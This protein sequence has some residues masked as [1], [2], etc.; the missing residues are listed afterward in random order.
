M[1][2]RPE[3]QKQAR[4]LAPA[5]P[6]QLS[7]RSTVIILSVLC[8][9]GIALRLSH[10][11]DVTSRTPDE[12][13][14]AN[15]AQRLVADGPPGLP[16]LID[17]YNW[18]ATRWIYPPPM[19]AGYLVLLA[20][21]MKI[22]TPDMLTGAWLSCFFSVLSLA[23]LAV[24]G[25]RFL[26]P[27]AAIYAVFGLSVSLCDLV[28]ARRC[29]QDAL[30]GTLG[31]TMVWAACEIARDHTRWWSYA[32]LIATGSFSVCVKE[33]G[34]VIYGGCVL[35]VLL[36]LF[37]RKA[38]RAMAG[39]IVAGLAAAGLSFY[40]LILAAGGLTPLLT[41]WQ[42]MGGALKDN[43]YAWEYQNLPWYLFFRGFWIVGPVNLLLAAFA[44]VLS[45]YRPAAHPLL[46]LFSWITVLLVVVILAA[47]TLENFRYLSPVYGPLYILGGIGLSSLLEI[48]ARKMDPGAYK[49]VAAVAVVIV[50]IGAMSQYRHFEQVYVKKSTPDLSLKL[51]LDTEG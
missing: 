30:V 50:L 20:A 44:V 32:V 29:W 7:R 12:T 42:H 27:T 45:V 40:S 33:I 14:Y 11:D 8:L 4:K 10:M 36:I 24:I 49:A 21:G 37:Q 2:P 43:P 17:Q 5:A 34:A 46:R 31:L 3:K 23:L 35:Y 6:P 18:D 47:P 19:R 28:I 1:P 25:V 16:A 48:A 22:S 26:P 51:V 9:F 38:W 39:M 41:A 15:Y 13:I